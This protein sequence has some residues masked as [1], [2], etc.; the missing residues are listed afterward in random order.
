MKIIEKIKSTIDR[1]PTDYV[2]T[3]VDIPIE[4]GKEATVVKYLNR[5]AAA[6]VISKLSKGKYY[7]PRQT[8]F[9]ALKPS[10]YQIAKDFIEKDGK[11]IGYLTG[12]SVFNEL[13]LTTQISNALQIGTN[14]YRRAVK[15]EIYT[16]SFVFQP[17]KITK[18][19]IELLRILDAVRFIKEI[20]ATTPDEVCIRFK[21]IFRKLAPKKKAELTN[22]AL[23]YTN[24]VRA[25]CGAI[26]ESI[27]TERALLNRLQKS[28]NAV[29]DYKTPISENI[30]PT[31]TKWR[32]R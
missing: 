4:G 3:Y 1:F 27:G 20:P 26:L 13:R 16:I 14:K 11:L 24:S 31:K 15:R 2:F 18:D 32:L 10:P 19:N 21:E 5:M 22:L 12:Y 23:Q 7:K 17:N 8:Q 28:L 25:L 29:T 30:L 9:G 6:G